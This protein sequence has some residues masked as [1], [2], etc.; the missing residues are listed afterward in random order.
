MSQRRLEIA[1]SWSGSKF[2]AIFSGQILKS[3]VNI[4]MRFGVND[5]S[6]V[7][8]ATGNSR[9]GIPGNSRESRTPKFPAGI[10]G[11]F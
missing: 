10:P 9:S 7:T 8:K 3:I 4:L 2:I 5:T 11:N 6:D 1:I